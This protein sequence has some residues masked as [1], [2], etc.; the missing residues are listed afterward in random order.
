MTFWESYKTHPKHGWSHLSKACRQHVNPASNSWLNSVASGRTSDLNSFYS[1]ISYEWSPSICLAVNKFWAAAH[2]L[3]FPGGRQWYQSVSAALDQA[4]IQLSSTLKLF[5][6]VCH[7]FSEVDRLYRGQCLASEKADVLPKTNTFQKQ[8]HIQEE[9][10]TLAYLWPVPFWNWYM[11]YFSFMQINVFPKLQ[12]VLAEI[13]LNSQENFWS[14]W[15][16]PRPSHFTT[17]KSSIYC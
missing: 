3:C 2:Q 5:A 6:L 13:S 8:Q 11:L 4:S 10:R 16:A 12:Y 14:L 1:N 7:H 9:K 17:T 15:P